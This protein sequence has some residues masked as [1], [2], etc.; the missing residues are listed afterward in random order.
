M[1]LL[2]AILLSSFSACEN[3]LPAE[4][5]ILA[6]TIILGR[7]SNSMAFPED[8]YQQLVDDV[9]QAVYGGFISVVISD[10]SPRAI[11]ITDKNGKEITFEADAN[12]DTIRTRR[13]SDRTNAV[14]EFL[15]DESN[16]ATS[17]ENDLMRAI[18]EARASLNNPNI[19]TNAERKIIIIDTGISTAGDL[20]LQDIQL[21]LNK[22]D[23]R[24]ILA[25]LN[26]AE[27]ILPD[28]S[29]INVSIIGLGDVAEPQEMSDENK[30]YLKDLWKTILESCGAEIEDA[31]ILIA[32]IGGQNGIVSGSIPNKSEDQGG[33]F[34]PITVIEFTTHTPSFD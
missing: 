23:P 9:Q 6:V 17:P 32:G 24:D 28:L 4:E 27:G 26:R 18:K 1:F 2:T 34:P 22:P 10:G 16:R 5:N 11:P 12:N 19:P 31:D 7:H 30:I 20:R 14:M 13:I 8:Y 29:K 25:E 3:T 15:R 33:D 21:D